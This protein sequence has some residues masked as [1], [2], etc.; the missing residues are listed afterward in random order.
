MQRLVAEAR[1]RAAA[2][3]PQDALIGFIGLLISEAVPKKDLIDALDSA[4]VDVT[5]A[6]AGSA[7]ELRA[8]IGHLL[9]RAQQTGGIR[10]DIDV[11]DLM[12]LLS[13]MI[14]AS[15]RRPGHQIDP[16]RAI[17]VLSDGLRTPR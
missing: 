12:A 3:D 9:T 1:A 15:Q 17:A 13:G 4:G 8:E 5:S 6:I 16:R 10:D 7:G 11:T 2:A 14:L